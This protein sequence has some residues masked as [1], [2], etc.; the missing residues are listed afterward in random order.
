[1]EEILE[2]RVSTCGFSPYTT[3]KCTF[4]SIIKVK[5]FVSK[6]KVLLIAKGFKKKSIDELA[7][8]AEKNGLKWI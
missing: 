2:K 8:F 1:M 3:I 6:P 4:N 5:D 7:S